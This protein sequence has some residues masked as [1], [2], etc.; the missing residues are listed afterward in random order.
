MDEKIYYMKDMDFFEGYDSTNLS[1]HLKTNANK[2]QLEEVVEIAH[3]ISISSDEEEFD[4]LMAE[5][6]CGFY[7]TNINTLKEYAG[8]GYSMYELI[9][10][11]AKK[12]GYTYKQIDF[13]T[14]EWN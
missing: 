11:V 2:S 4:E 5:K 12:L 6:N 10:E 8:A 13:E 3:I 14:I 1:F 7:L 9:E